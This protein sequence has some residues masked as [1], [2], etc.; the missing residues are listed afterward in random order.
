MAKTIDL[1][2]EARTECDTEE[3]VNLIV[4]NIRNSEDEL[5]KENNYVED[6]CN[7]CKICNCHEIPYSNT[8]PANL[9]LT[10][11]Q[12]EGNESLSY[13]S[14]GNVTQKSPS[15]SDLPASINRWQQGLKEA[16]MSPSNGSDNMHKSFANE[17]PD[18]S[19]QSALG[20][21]TFDGKHYS[22]SNYSWSN[23]GRTSNEYSSSRAVDFGACTG[24]ENAFRVS[25]MYNELHRT[26]SE[27]SNMKENERYIRKHHSPNSSF[28]FNH[29]RNFNL[30]AKSS[31]CNNYESLKNS[32]PSLSQNAYKT[33]DSHY[34]SCDFMKYKMNYWQNGMEAHPNKHIIN[35]NENCHK[36][37]L[38]KV[39]E[40]AITL[41]QKSLNRDIHRGFHTVNVDRGT[42]ERHTVH[43]ADNY[44]SVNENTSLNAIV[45]N[46]VH[47]PKPT[48]PNHHLQ[49]NQKY[50]ETGELRNIASEMHSKEVYFKSTHSSMNANNECS[51]K[52][53]SE[54]ENISITEQ[55]KYMLNL[56]NKEYIHNKTTS[57][58]TESI[59][60][61][62]MH[63]AQEEKTNNMT[64]DGGPKQF[65]SIE[66]IQNTVPQTTT[67]WK[68]PLLML[69]NKGCAPE[70]NKGINVA[71]DFTTNEGTTNIINREQA[72]KAV[73]MALDSCGY[74]KDVEEEETYQT[75][76]HDTQTNAT[77]T[78][79]LSNTSKLTAEGMMSD[80]QTNFPNMTNSE[81]SS[82]QCVYCNKIFPTTKLLKEHLK[83]HPANSP[84][85]C[86]HCDLKFSSKPRYL[87]HSLLHSKE[88]PYTCE[89][90]HKCFTT[91][92]AFHRHLHAKKHSGNNLSI[93]KQ[94]G[95][96]FIDNVYMSLHFKTHTGEHPFQCDIC[97]NIFACKNNLKNHIMTHTGEKPFQCVHC[98]KRFVTNFSL[99]VHIRTHTKDYPYSC[100]ICKKKFLCSS[101]MT[102]HVR[103]HTGEK[104]HQCYKCGKFFSSLSGIQG[105]QRTH[106]GE[107]PYSC[108]ICNK[109]FASKFSLRIHKRTHTGENPHRCTYC[110]KTF[111]NSSNMRRHLR[112][113]TGE[114]PYSCTYCSKAF[115]SSTYL[116]SHIR[117]HTGE[118][119][120]K[121][122]YCGKEFSNTL[123]FK[124]HVNNHEKNSSNPLST[125]KK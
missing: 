114:R 89:E 29:S 109:S 99:K 119:P 69:P 35:C 94:C 125:G 25:L 47:N 70:V 23:K 43:S 82:L 105:H 12:N 24:H 78:T 54:P 73:T 86:L 13:A 8:R 101:N 100:K 16:N 118:K 6:Y 30:E 55:N 21:N 48:Q 71:D 77:E 79:S 104:R 31:K 14:D 98:A 61:S 26:H 38:D 17:T 90:C 4:P 76:L 121:C 91:V 64:P 123:C 107:C 39:P 22:P 7:N 34:G 63:S 117:T 57:S 27:A 97:G 42:K 19:L 18:S 83:S 84:Y 59:P 53:I 45:N 124:Q 88:K 93:C 68:A 60:V 95:L 33:V 80:S 112:I 32:E 2:R 62:V 41:S 3:P 37:I 85:L 66:M 92:T 122:K 81:N 50:T 52:N 40:S 1:L 111:S 74:S 67:I 120:Y 36:E 106:T 102:S 10:T 75:T 115:C 113:H 103:T 110:N 44:C 20:K 11:R 9:L 65:N 5:L 49:A 58:N 108:N 51:E 46:A 72:T 56:K 96:S 28:N 87:R 15:I 116:K